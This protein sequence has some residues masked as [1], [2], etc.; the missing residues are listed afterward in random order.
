MS[1]METIFCLVSRGPRPVGV[2]CERG[3][4]VANSVLTFFT[5]CM[6]MVFICKWSLISLMYATQQYFYMDSMNGH[7]AVHCLA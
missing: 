5:R 3:E 7:N 4:R 6:C 1:A 2:M